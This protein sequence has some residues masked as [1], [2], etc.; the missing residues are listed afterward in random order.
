MPRIPPFSLPWPV[1]ALAA[2]AYFV[3]TTAHNVSTRQQVAVLSC[4]VSAPNFEIGSEHVSIGVFCPG[5]DGVVA[6]YQRPGTVM[7]LNARR[8]KP[9]PCAEFRD[10]FDDASWECDII[11]G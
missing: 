7:Y 9:V 11:G 8:E 1:L 3:T 6:V 2:A 5:H 10:G 4:T